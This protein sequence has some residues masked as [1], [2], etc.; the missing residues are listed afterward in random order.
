MWWIDVTLKGLSK[1]VKHTK[2]PSVVAYNEMNY[3]MM[4]WTK[5]WR[6]EKW[7]D[8]TLEGLSKS[9]KYTKWP[10]ALAYD[11]MNIHVKKGGVSNYEKKMCWS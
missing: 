3:E 2:W 7:N 11:E 6:N 8:K 1:S 5:K 10:N 9:V 4:K